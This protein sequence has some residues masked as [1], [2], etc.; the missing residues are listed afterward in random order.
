LL[1]TG[2]VS[3]AVEPVQGAQRLLGPGLVGIGLGGGD[4]LAGQMGI[5][6]ISG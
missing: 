5:I 3:G 4:E 1:V 2:V 6:P